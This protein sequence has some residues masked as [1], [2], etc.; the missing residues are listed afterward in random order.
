[1]T[2]VYTIGWW[3]QIPAA[4]PRAGQ[5]VVHC[6]RYVTLAHHGGAGSDCIPLVIITHAVFSSFISSLPT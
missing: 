4:L 6:T 1:M 2:G 3:P 5:S